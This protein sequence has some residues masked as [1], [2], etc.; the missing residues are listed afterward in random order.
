MA[1]TKNIEKK[2][3]DLLKKFNLD[4]IL[5]IPVNKL[6]KS[7]GIKLSPY[8]LGEG[9]SGVLM[10]DKGVSKIG[11]NA[12]ESYVR[13]RFTLAHELGHFELHC[14]NKD[15][16]LFVDNTKYLF[17]KQPKGSIEAQR[18]KEANE[19]AAALLMPKT[20]V[21]KEFNLLLENGYFSDDEI[22]SSLAKKFKVSQIAMT[23]RLKNLDYMHL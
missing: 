20:L 6:I 1:T 3:N 7:S 14:K 5:P 8:D 23:Y 13:Q 10:I 18:E 11:Y 12:T 17:R 9:V 21:K 19:F 2:A 22:I 4:N 15:K 16:E